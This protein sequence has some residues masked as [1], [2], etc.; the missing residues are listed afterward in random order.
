[1]HP[2]YLIHYN[3]NHSAKNG[4]FTSGDGDGDGISND[5]AHRSKKKV[6]LWKYKTDTKEAARK[7]KSIGMRQIGGG[8]ATAAAGG[9]LFLTANTMDRPADST[10]AKVVQTGAKFVSAYAA[11]VGVGAIIGGSINAVRGAKALKKYN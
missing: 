8:I 5:H 7:T 3:K 2:D 10:L 4:Q 9:A 6:D 1:M 11:A